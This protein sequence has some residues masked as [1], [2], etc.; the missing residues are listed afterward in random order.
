MEVRRI[1]LEEPFGVT[2]A[3]M[4]EV[5][6]T[7]SAIRSWWGVSRAI[8]DLREGGT[9][10]TAWGEGEESSDHV[11][12]FKIVELDAPNRFVLGS[13]RSI[14]Q[15]STVE[16]HITT[17]FRIDAYPH[18]CNLRIVVMLD[19]DDSFYDDYFDASV[20]GWENCF[21][22]IRNYLHN[23]PEAERADERVAAPAPIADEPILDPVEGDLDRELTPEEEFNV[24]K[25]KA[26]DL[27]I[28]DAALLAEASTSERKISW[29]VGKTM[30]SLGP[31]FDHIPAVFLARRVRKLI[32]E[33]KLE[34][35]G[36]TDYIRRKEAKP[37][38]KSK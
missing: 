24:S 38:K 8:V 5:L 23:H 28:I 22:G 36:D 34:T 19:T 14:T 2:P 18:G 32:G 10:V 33:G 11:T 6:T 12:S 37:P 15:G 3:R 27:K 25:L 17:E 1:E 4:F 31:N 35:N 7:P 13:S 20:I 16:T 9:W 30:K 29:V 26:K 21:E